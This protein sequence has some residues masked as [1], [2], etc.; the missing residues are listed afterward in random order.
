MK[1]RIKTS[2]IIYYN[3]LA[4]RATGYS[5]DNND[6]NYVFL[7]EK[8]DNDFGYIFKYCNVEKSKNNYYVIEPPIKLTSEEEDELLLKVF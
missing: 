1:R 8:A 7:P 4:E 3:S 2:D 5:K 6:L